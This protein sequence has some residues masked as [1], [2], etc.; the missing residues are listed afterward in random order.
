[1]ELE[2]LINA[3]MSPAAYPHAAADVRLCQTHMSAVFLAGQYVYKIK[4][5]VNLGFADFRTLEA[6]EHFCH[7]EVRLNSR[8]A[9]SVYLG[10]APITRSADEIQ[11]DGHGVPIEWAVKMRRL[12]DEASLKHAILHGNVDQQMVKVLAKRV[13]GFHSSAAGSLAIAEFG[14]FGVVAGNARENLVQMAPFVDRVVS[15]TVLE[16][17]T[18]LTEGQL[19]RLR[20]LIE[21]RAERG[22]PRD[23][24]GDLRLDHVYLFPERTE[25]DDLV[26]IDCIEFNERFRFADPVADM[27]FLVMD[28]KANGRPDL[29]EAFAEAYFRASGDEEGRDLLPFYVSYRALVRAKVGAFKW[30]E[31][32]VAEAERAV[33]LARSR[34]HAL[35]AL[36]ELEEPRQRPCLILTAGLPGTGKSTLAIDL[37]VHANLH[38]VRT[39]IVRKELAA[40]MGLRPDPASPTTAAIY[41]EE[42]NQRTYGECLR[43]VEAYL[44]DGQR[45]IVDGNFRTE[46]QRNEFR[47]AAERWGVP[48]VVLVCKSTPE[49]VRTR[50]E[51]RKGDASD[52]DW[53]V[54]QRLAG[55]WQEPSKDERRFVSEINTAGVKEA[56]L[57]QARAVL[58]AAR[59]L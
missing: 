30:D 33:A 41:T 10:V 19:A 3:M 48:F 8:L 46:S 13:A 22:V 54:Y 56:T 43:K 5:P 45:V 29:G 52:A 23:T 58:H 50:L 1:M 17:L 26:I 55:Q 42:W 38:V 31:P 40:S 18:T 14:R 27:A 20:S 59:L 16:R 36:G 57:E 11:V 4:K 21:R 51:A 12:P 39:D 37:A 15:R 24:H 7:E 53:T 2:H 9:P 6:R 49:I 32:E 28:F 25:P 35:H 44:F 34:A 47:E